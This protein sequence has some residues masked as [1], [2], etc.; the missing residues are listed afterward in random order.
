MTAFEIYRAALSARLEPRGA[1][2]Q[3]TLPVNPDGVHASTLYSVLEGRKTPSL[4]LA[5]RL[6]KLAGVEL[7]ELLAPPD[8]VSRE[9]KRRAKSVDA[10]A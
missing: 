7:W 5:E 2:R 4:E 10:P 6:A 1:K 8:V 9:K 3:I